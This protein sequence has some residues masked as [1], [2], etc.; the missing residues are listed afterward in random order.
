MNPE[1]G[2]IIDR[3]LQKIA[4][5]FGEHG[6]A[7]AQGTIALLATVL[8]MAAREYDRGAEIRVVENAELRALFGELAPLV[9]DDALKAKLEAAAAS[10]DPSLRISALNEANYALRNLLTEAMIH[11]EDRDIGPA[12]KRIWAAMKEVAARRLVQLG[13]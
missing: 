2:L 5:G 12:K 3:S 7:F 4:G 6:A 13:P 11:A 8:G 1:V 9:G 10:K